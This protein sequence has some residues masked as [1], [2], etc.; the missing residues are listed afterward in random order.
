MRECI[1]LSCL[2]IAMY[3]LISVLLLAICELYECFIKWKEKKR[4]CQK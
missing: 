4:K 2:T 1:Y 3:I